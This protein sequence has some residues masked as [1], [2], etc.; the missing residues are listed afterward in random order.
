MA[1]QVSAGEI[2][3]GLP[4]Q[5]TLQQRTITLVERYDSPPYERKKRHQVLYNGEWY[6]PVQYGRLRRQ[7]QQEQQQRQQQTSGSGTK[8][9]GGRKKR[10]TRKPKKRH[11]SK[12][13][14]HKT[15]RKRRRTKRR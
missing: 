7:E 11:R 8:E 1:G 9:K 4:H 6:S 10:K 5:S 12:T 2:V 13:R 15:K 3:A 14:K